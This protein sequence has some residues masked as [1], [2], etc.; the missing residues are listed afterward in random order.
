MM[1]DCIE[2]LLDRTVERWM[3]VAMQ[4]DPDGR[5]PIEIPLSVRIDQVGPFPSLI[6]SGSSCSHSCIWV[7]G[8]QRY[9]RSQLLNCLVEGCRAIVEELEES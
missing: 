5:G 4:I 9:F 7:K 6:M 2:L 8:C 3:T 1:C